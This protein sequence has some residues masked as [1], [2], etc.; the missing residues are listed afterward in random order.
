MSQCHFD[1]AEGRTNNRHL[2]SDAVDLEERLWAS[3]ET[4]ERDANRRAKARRTQVLRYRSFVL[5]PQPH[6]EPRQVGRLDVVKSDLCD[7][8]VDL[9]RRGSEEGIDREASWEVPAKVHR[10]L[11]SDGILG[12]RAK[13]K[14]N[15]DRKAMVL[16]ATRSAHPSADHPRT[17]LVARWS[18]ITI[19]SSLLA[20]HIVHRCNDTGAVSAPSSAIAATHSRRPLFLDDPVNLLPV[21]RRRV[22]LVQSHLEGRRLARLRRLGG[23]LGFVVF[24][25]RRDG[26]GLARSGSRE[27]WGGREFSFDGGF[28][29]RRGS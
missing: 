5:V 23:G 27:S 26:G 10:R 1:G 28:A 2:G 13:H 25:G 19:P 11:V 21:L 20:S 8:R 24:V 9:F 16:Y 17:H 15:Q 14:R 29:G 3:D 22:S 4:S 6:C 12:L 18:F 7:A